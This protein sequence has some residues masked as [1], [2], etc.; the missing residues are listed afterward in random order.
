[1][2]F[3]DRMAHLEGECTRTLDAYKALP[4]RTEAEQEV[5]LAAWRECTRANN[6]YQNALNQAAPLLL[7]SVSALSSITPAAPCWECGEY[8]RCAPECGHGQARSLLGKL[9]ALKPFASEPSMLRS[10]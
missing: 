4:N 9:D 6:H 7:A 2:S 1:V 5:A 8:G 3:L 10:R